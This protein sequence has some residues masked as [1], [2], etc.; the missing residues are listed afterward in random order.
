M[1]SETGQTIV[2]PEVRV[3]EAH[4]GED[5][6]LRDISVDGHYACD[7]QGK[8]MYFNFDEAKS[9]LEKRGKSLASLPLLVNLYL[10]L[11]ELAR[12][13]EIAAQVLHQLNAVWNRTGT[14]ISAAGSIVHSDAILG[15]ITYEGLRV[16]QEANG[17]IADLFGN[18]QQF[19][20]A[21]LGVRD[22]DRLVDVATRHDLI[23]Y[24]W[25]PRGER[26]V[27]FGGG[28]FYYMHQHIPSL[29]MVF[30]DDVSHPQRVVRGVWVGR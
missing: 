9:Y 6:V 29:L 26:L 30:C 18:N 19:F 22:I 14:S 4:R 25:Y 28:D 8:V 12:R 17:N 11:D 5:I 20:K 13:D 2:I 7:S 27:M 16:P 15:E 3:Y 23:P 24:Y 1:V 21:L 10:A